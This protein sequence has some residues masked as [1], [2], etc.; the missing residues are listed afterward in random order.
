[1][2]FEHPNLDFIAGQS[3]LAFG[4]HFWP[5]IHDIFHQVGSRARNNTHF[6]RTLLALLKTSKLERCLPGAIEDA[7]S[8]FE[9]LLPSN[10]S[11]VVNSPEL[12]RTVFKQNTRLF[13]ADDFA[14]DPK[15]FAKT[16]G[17]LDVILHSY[18]PFYAFLNW[19]PEPS[20]I[21]RRIARWGLQRVTRDLYRSRKKNGTIY[22][23]DALQ[24]MIDN[25]D[26]EDYI[27]E[28]CVSASFITSTNAHIILAEMLT[29]M[30]VHTDWQ[31]K[32]YQEVVAAANRHCQ[33]KDMPLVNKLKFIP[34]TTWESSFPALGL[35]LYEVIRVWTSFAAG[36]YNVSP[37]PIPI[38]GSDE[39]IPGHTFAVYN[40]T[41]IN[42]NE[43]LFPEPAKFDPMRFTEGREEFKQE[44]H[45]C[46]C[47]S[48]PFALPG[49][50]TV[51]I[52]PS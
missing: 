9:A 44:P 3:L 30:A 24:N 18:S 10:P 33:D 17:Y 2:F 22:K 4:L 21:R 26:P 13:F 47:P 46:K 41:E 27:N 28:F 23:D 43:K 31:E 37:D 6:L 38:P 48:K 8:D 5:P 51:L 49:E 25:N 14:N 15:L 35:C 45:G 34:I 42:F 20:M 36:R 7:R 40:S 16:A 1:M 39:V 29:A 19:I 32:V 11:G 50:E 52:A 12:W